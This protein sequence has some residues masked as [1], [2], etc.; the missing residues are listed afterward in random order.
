[1]RQPQQDVLFFKALARFLT[2]IPPLFFF[3]SFSFPDWLENLWADTCPSP[4]KF[5]QVKVAPK[6]KEPRGRG[7]W[8]LCHHSCT[9]HS[10]PLISTP[11]PPAP[12]G[13]RELLCRLPSSLHFVQIG[14][15]WRPGEEHL[16]AFQVPFIHPLTPLSAFRKPAG[17]AGAAL[18][19]SPS[20]EAFSVPEYPGPTSASEK[21][22][23]RRIA[24]KA[25]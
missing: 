24:Y 10:P 8:N 25:W 12:P 5:S 20:R 2:W 14:P 23:C 21:L 16:G 6:T 15:S 3:F 9:P 19:G 22:T 13:E 17:A 18:G 7:F 1:M 4:L 11:S